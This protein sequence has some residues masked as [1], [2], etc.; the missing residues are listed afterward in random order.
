MDVVFPYGQEIYLMKKHLEGED[1]EAESLIS[2]HWNIKILVQMGVCLALGYCLLWVLLAHCLQNC[3]FL[4]IQNDKVCY[5]AL[6]PGLF[7][8]NLSIGH[9]C[10]QSLIKMWRFEGAPF[11]CL[12]WR[13][14]C[15]QRP[16]QP[17][18]FILWALH[19]ELKGSQ[20]RRPSSV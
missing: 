5:L 19:Y 10:L 16:P 9:S 7:L 1:Q 18:H 6:I 12:A 8:K 17:Y 2:T 14:S 20:D 15:P 3:V 11:P 13:S 4:H